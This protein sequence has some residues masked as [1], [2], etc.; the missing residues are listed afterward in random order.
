[1]G[2]ELGITPQTARRWLDLLVATFQW[3]EVP[4]YSGNAIKRVSGKP[5]GY[6]SDTGLACWAQ[7]V[8]SPAVLGGHP[9]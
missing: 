2:R 3:Y 7:A 9:I 1:L 5:K 4:A 6:L 8:S